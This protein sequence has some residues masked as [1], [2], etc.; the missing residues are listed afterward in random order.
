MAGIIGSI[1]PFDEGTEQWTS[2]TERF[3]CFVAA[4]D[5]AVD[6]LMPMFLSVVRVKTFNL[7]RCLVQPEKPANINY[8]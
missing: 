7:L 2:Y 5:I 6:K 8:P 4:N 1:G 3:D